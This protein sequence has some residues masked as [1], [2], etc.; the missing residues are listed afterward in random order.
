MQIFL[1]NVISD[2]PQSLFLTSFCICIYLFLMAYTQLYKSL[3]PSGGPSIC[4]FVGPWALVQKCENAHFR[5]CPPICNWYW[6]CIRPCFHFD[7]RWNTNV[8]FGGTLSYTNLWKYISKLTKLNAS[9]YEFDLRTLRF[10]VHD[11]PVP[12]RSLNRVP[13]VSFKWSMILIDF[14]YHKW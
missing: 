14:L 11:S 13:T 4:Q 6:L 3:C 2:P 7:L 8:G 1:L 10:N 9:S 5:P 12:S